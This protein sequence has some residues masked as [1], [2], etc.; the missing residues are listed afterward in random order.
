ML[1]NYKS[2]LILARGIKPRIN[3]PANS[4]QND[5]TS[6]INQVIAN[7]NGINSQLPINPG[8]EVHPYKG[9]LTYTNQ[10]KLI[11]GTFPP[12]SYLIDSIKTLH[13]E[14]GLT[15]LSQPTPPNQG[16]SHPTISFF[17]GNI[18]AL[19]SVL[20]N[21]QELTTL[22]GFLP[23]NRVGAKNFLIAKMNKLGIYYDDIILSTQRKLGVVDN[24][25][26]NLGY[27]YQDVHLKNIS[28]DNDLITKFLSNNDS[29]NI[30]F[31]N[32]AT[33]GV[34]GLQL[35][36]QLNR[37]GKVKVTG[38][39][40]FSLFL[41]GCQELGLNIEL[42]CLPFYTWTPISALNQTQL[43]TKLIF[44]IRIIKTANCI[45]PE[46][47]NFT[48]K[49]FTVVTPFSP[50]A[51][52]NIEYHPIVNNYRAI[53]GVAS[54]STVLKDF[55]GKFRNNQHTLLYPYNI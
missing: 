49:E 29:K 45:N 32:G 7:V 50:A 25:I 47:H 21:P 38:N 39:D 31:T 15:S 10:E 13:P 5:N 53:N 48:Q 1:L 34:N 19:W 6:F 22:N 17:H 35:H 44:E 43:S 42:Q 3:L 26:G 20:L 30:C 51:H 54:I 27:T 36:T 41:R 24:N 37:L 8:F 33:F 9:L 55:Y 12:I 46:L 40:A 18:S 4:I 11:I 14:I 28:I 2:N 23:A 52:G 16:I